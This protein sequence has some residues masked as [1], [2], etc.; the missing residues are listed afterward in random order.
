MDWLFGGHIHALSPEGYLG[1]PAAYEAV[2]VE[3]YLN[4]MSERLVQAMTPGG[5]A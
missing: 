3:G 5:A 2:D 1:D 4:D